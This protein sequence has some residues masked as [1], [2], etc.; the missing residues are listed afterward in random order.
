MRRLFGILSF[1]LLAVAGPLHAAE[2]D[3]QRDRDLARVSTYLNGIQSIEGRFVQI[4][5]DGKAQDGTFYLRKPGRLRFEYDRPNPNLIVADGS[6]IAVSNTR[7]KTTDRYP[8]M[9][10]P[11]RLLISEN[12][13]LASDRRISEVRREPGT[14]IVTARQTTGP[15]A[16]QGAISLFFAD[17]GSGLELRQWEVLDAQGLRTQVALS[18]LKSGVNLNPRLFVIQDLSPFSQR[19]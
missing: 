18:S 19:R 9:E 7:L 4:G 14:L 11:L 10:S 2:A 5:P 12:V 3:A 17:S 16:A 1:A 15:Q 8:L 13:N 6:T